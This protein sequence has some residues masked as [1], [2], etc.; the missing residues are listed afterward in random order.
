MT[1]PSST[2]IVTTG[3]DLAFLVRYMKAPRISEGLRQVAER[4]RAE[5]WTYE[6]FLEEILE[7]EVFARQ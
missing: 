1:D 7:R 6:H 2:S 4:A 5:S 3:A